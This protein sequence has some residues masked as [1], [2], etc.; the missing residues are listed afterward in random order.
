MMIDSFRMDNELAKL[1]KEAADAEEF[2]NK[3]VEA[4]N[5]YIERLMPIIK[6][7]GIKIVSSRMYFNSIDNKH[8]HALAILE[9]AE[10]YGNY[11]SL[12]VKRLEKELRDA[13]I[14]M[15][16]SILATSITI[17]LYDETL[18]R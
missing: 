4:T 12:K 17:T 1:K 7:R 6:K 13:G 9:Y 8:S 5:R 14:P 2:R 15:P 16:C 3:A 18:N 10:K 11:K